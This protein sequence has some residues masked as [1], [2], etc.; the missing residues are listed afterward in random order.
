MAR[1]NIRKRVR[2]DGSIAYMVRVELPADPSTGKRRTPRTGTFNTAKE[3]ERMK[4]KWLSEIDG[5]MTVQPAKLVMRDL[6]RRWLEDEA[7]QRV[8]ATTLAG[9]R[10][11][12]ETHVIPR[13]GSIRADRLTAADVQRFVAGL[14]RETSPRTAQLALTRLKQVLQWAVSVELLT[15][16]VA[17]GVTRPKWQPAERVVWNADEA[18]TFLATVQDDEL[19]PLWLLALVT[20]LRRGELLALRWEDLD[21]GTSRLMVKQSLVMLGGKTLIQP[22]KSQAAVRSVRLPADVITTLQALHDR[23]EFARR[24]AGERWKE[25]DLIFTS[26][27]GTPLSPRNV[28]RS[29]DAAIAKANIRRIRL[30]DLRHVSASL[31]L[32]SGTSVKAVAA[33][34]GHSDPSITLRT[35]AH[36]LP[37]EEAAA[38]ARLGAM[39]SIDA[40]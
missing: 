34:L 3:A 37:S 14:Y 7:A 28:G 32:A 23:Q 17:I 22:P 39:L 2:N 40:G 31:D 27:V 19:G 24:K 30:H 5:G 13:I 26:S 20:G 15:R 12:I 8:R 38:V 29:F 33:R 1:G 18:R 36:V 35:Y 16:N 6:L 25:T 9:Y 11:S 10:I 4:T 21:V